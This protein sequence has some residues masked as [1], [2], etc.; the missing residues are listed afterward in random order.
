MENLT[1]THQLMK[2]H[3]I[4]TLEDHTVVVFETMGSAGDKFR[5]EIQ[6]GAVPPKRSTLTDWLPWRNAPNF[7][8][9]AVPARPMT[10][11]F[12][13]DIRMD[14]NLHQFVMAIHITYTVSDPRLLVIRRAADPLRVVRDEIVRLVQQ[15]VAPYR[16]SDVT[17]NF[18]VVERNASAEVLTAS[19]QVASSFGLR[20]QDLTLSQQITRDQ[21]PELVA[22]NDT[23]VKLLQQQLEHKLRQQQA[24]LMLKQRELDD[25]LAA[26]RRSAEAADAI[27]AAL[28]TA[29]QNAAG[30][31]T[32][33]AEIIQTI[34]SL[35][36]LVFD[37]RSSGSGPFATAL[38]SAA[39]RAQIAAVSQNGIA[40]VLQQLVA[41]T[42]QILCDRGLKRR[43]QAAMLHLVATLLPEETP[44]P[45]A[46]RER[47]SAVA[48]LAAEARLSGRQ[49][50]ALAHFI[51]VSTLRDAL[52]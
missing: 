33:P 38:P 27:V 44:D 47:A 41:E 23:D 45:A 48:A 43:L 7:F 5:Y 42:E 20:I 10:A 26:Y 17:N 49:A 25:E 40:P 9:Y 39:N 34:A 14:D 31:V 4:D 50:D 22:T 3:T 30:A 29:L 13:A 1:L 21:I 37:L 6:P 51:N 8:A 18:R 24:E 32:N 15:S 46:A 28:R 19:K 2:E 12:G 35:N 16:W 11:Q 52:Q 36:S